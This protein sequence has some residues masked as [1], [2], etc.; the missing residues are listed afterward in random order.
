MDESNTEQER[1]IGHIHSELEDLN[2]ALAGLEGGLENLATILTPVMRS[3]CT[4][5]ACG[6]S[7]PDA[8]SDCP[9]AG[10]IS[11][12]CRATIRLAG[13]V[14]ELKDRLEV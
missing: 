7:P 8:R 1:R 11:G 5:A 10:E 14:Q 13:V 2:T 9:L 3:P 12:C 4:P 6:V